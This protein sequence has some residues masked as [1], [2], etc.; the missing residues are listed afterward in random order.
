MQ[1]K[2]QRRRLQSGRSQAFLVMAIVLWAVAAACAAYPVQT[3]VI[4]GFLS[5]LS[6]IAAMILWAYACFSRKTLS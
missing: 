6:V 1:T 2:A 5:I 3:A 4:L